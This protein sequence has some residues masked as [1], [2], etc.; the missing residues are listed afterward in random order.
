MLPFSA[1]KFVCDECFAIA[2]VAVPFLICCG[3][4]VVP[5]QAAAPAEASPA[6]LS[7]LLLPLP[8]APA[9]VGDTPPVAGTSM[10]SAAGV[11]SDGVVVM[12]VVSDEPDAS[13][14]VTA[15]GLPMLS[16]LI[17]AVVVLRAAGAG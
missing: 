17:D 6:R 4:V 10:L 15:L 8:L 7:L 1:V 2:D 5:R 13:S 3:P 14:V 11:G 16:L 12:V 9:V